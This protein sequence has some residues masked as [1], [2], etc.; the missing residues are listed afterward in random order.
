MVFSSEPADRTALHATSAFYPLPITALLATHVPVSLPQR[1][2]LT[3]SSRSHAPPQ[4][5]P[6][7]ARP[8][9][10]TSSCNPATLCS[11]F[12]PSTLRRA[13]VKKQ[14]WFGGWA[15]ARCVEQGVARPTL[16]QARLPL[17]LCPP[18]T[19]ASSPSTPRPRPPH[20]RSLAG[21]DTPRRPSHAPGGCRRLL[22]RFLPHP[23]HSAAFHPVVAP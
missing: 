1:A 23:L 14:C 6:M 13:C 21:R 10:R 7:Q 3:A 12:V 2:A 16:L 18:L 22:R 11:C 9:P 17:S 5:C 4:Q 8:Q 19:W 20:L 15:A